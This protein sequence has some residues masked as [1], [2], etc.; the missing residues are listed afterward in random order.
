M[1]D[2]LA[3][4]RRGRHDL[5]RARM[6]HVARRSHDH[7]RLAAEQAELLAV[8][9]ADA[10]EERGEAVVVVLAV[11]LERMMVAL[12]ALQPHA[13]EELGRR[14]GQLRR[15]VGDAVVVGRAA[16]VDRALGRDQL[17]DEL[18]ER[19]VGA[20]RL[21]DPVVHGPHA[22]LAQLVAGVA[23]QVGPLERPAGGVLVVVDVLGRVAGEAQQAIDQLRALVG[24]GR[25]EERLASLRASAACRWRRGRPGGGTWR[26]RTA[27]KAR[28]PARGTWRRPACR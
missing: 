20:E 10:G 14:L 23:D 4:Q 22:L 28:C 25:L 13:E 17:A 15:I 11:L 6:P 7:D 19:L 9:G 5:V 8:L 26:R 3:V 12:G 16:R 21:L 24:I 18:V 27:A 2:R 1:I